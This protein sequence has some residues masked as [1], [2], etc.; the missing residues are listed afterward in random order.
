MTEQPGTG[1]GLAPDSPQA[2]A[3]VRAQL[4]ENAGTVAGDDTAAAAATQAQIAG[5]QRGPLLPAEQQIDELMAM[6]RQQSEQMAALLAKQGDQDKQMAALRGQLAA[7]QG[8]PLPVRYAQAAVDK[9][10]AHQAANPVLGK[11][12]FGPVVELGTHLLEAAG[13]VV[14][15]GAPDELLKTASA[16]ERWLTRTH[17][18]KA[19]GVHLDFS[20][21]LDDVENAVE[22]AQEMAKAA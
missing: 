4:A 21:V 8:E 10:T 19:G 15:G 13:L 14:N 9:L 17:P 12:H 7:A 1:G 22:A 16:V 11:D 18:R 20:S 3:A 6:F 5:T 2:Q